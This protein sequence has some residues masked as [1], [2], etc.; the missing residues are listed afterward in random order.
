MSLR[1]SVLALGAILVVVVAVP[2]A[3]HTPE[4]EKEEVEQQI[5][6]LAGRIGAQEGQRTA[7]QREIT[8]AQERMQTIRTQLSEARARLA[9]VE[10]DIQATEEEWAEL[11]NQIDD[12]QRELAL[13]RVD[14]RDTRLRIRSRAV[15]LYM[16]GSTE[17]RR[18]LFA[19]DEV[20][21]LVVGLSYARE[22]I[23]DSKALVNALEVLQ[24]EEERQTDQLETRQGTAGRKLLLLGQKRR[25]FEQENAAIAALEA[26]AHAEL[27]R[28]RDL[29]S[30][31]EREIAEYE[32]EMALAEEELAALEREIRERQSDA[33]S[34]PSR[35]AWPVNASVSS[36]FGF[37]IHPILGTRRL[38]AGIDL[39]AGYGT[40][41]K[42]AGSGKVILAAAYGGYGNT[43]VIDHGGG[44]TTLYAHQSSLA[45]AV[46][47]RVESGE[48]IGRVGSSGL[49]TGAHL[50]FETRID[51]RPV[52]PMQFLP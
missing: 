39:R 35:L 12:L 51:G 33:G 9:G 38:H 24:R 1:R 16:Q 36:P 15:E 26:E 30:R 52:D 5:A 41:V 34:T 27:D 23:D 2:V 25:V 19:I 37:R 46:G 8:A 44:L 49:S 40:L 4:E 28:Q 21:E 22:V 43:V 31:V 14:M 29:L 48:V 3:A 32:S 6:D 11:Q 13:T 50:H 20:A 10:Q 17:I 45:V 18:M 42:A 47:H 7:I